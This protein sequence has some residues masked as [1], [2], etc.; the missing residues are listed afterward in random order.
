MSLTLLLAAAARTVQYT[1]DASGSLT[2]E[3]GGGGR[4]YGLPLLLAVQALA[5]E[6]RQ[7]DDATT[8]TL[9]LSGAAVEDYTRGAGASAY[10]SVGPSVLPPRRRVRYVDAMAG[11]ISLTGY[12]QDT[13]ATDAMQ[14]EEELAL[15]LATTRIREPVG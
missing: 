14:F 12:G 4:A 11:T 1:D 2:L 9:T 3:R 13:L 10:Y 8:G 15:L 5:V 7:Y 6:S